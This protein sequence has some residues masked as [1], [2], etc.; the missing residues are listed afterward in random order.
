MKI[1]LLVA[2]TLPDSLT[3]RFSRYGNMYEG[4]LA[5]RGH[6]FRHYDARGGDLPVTADEADAWL[7]TGS[8]NGAYEDLPWIVALKTCLRGILKSNRPT[9]GICFGHQI[10]ADVLGGQVEKFDG[11]WSIGRTQY[12]LEDGKMLHAFAWHQDQVVT[13]PKQAIRLASSKHCENAMMMIS[14]YVLGIQPHPEFDADIVCTALDVYRDTLPRTL[15]AEAD[16]TVNQPV[17]RDVMINMID[18]FLSSDIRA[19][20]AL[21]QVLLDA[22][23]GDTQVP[24]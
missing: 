8:E 1:G 22:L 6:T 4:L 11:G 20:E 21:R 18:T 10:I 19:P 17:A 5:G 15:T 9:V 12:R 14:G 24:R 2:G 3:A 13:L 7:V 16:R 23:A